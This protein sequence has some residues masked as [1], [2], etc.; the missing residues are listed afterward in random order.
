MPESLYTLAAIGVV[1]AVTWA[2]RAAP[3]LL[4]GK[5]PLPAVMRYLGRF[6]PPVIMTV[7]VIYCL[8]STAFGAFPFGIPELAACAL[9]VALQCIRKNMYLSVIAGTL[10][11]MILL[12]VL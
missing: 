1:A 9:V 6:L 5:K 8:R 2:L 3:F 11:Y 10:C 12:R 4:F 7:L